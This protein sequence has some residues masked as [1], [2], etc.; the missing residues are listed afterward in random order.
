MSEDLTKKLPQS[1]SE[2]LTLI[3][4]TVEKLSERVEKLEARRYDTRPIWENVLADMAHLQEGQLA[5]GTEIRAMRRDIFNRFVVLNNTLL[6]I[7]AD[8]HDLHERVSR[9]ELGHRPP[10][11]ET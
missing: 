3:L 10:N 7:R 8:H 5:L 9:L 4:V 11:S 1:D 2:K 6:D